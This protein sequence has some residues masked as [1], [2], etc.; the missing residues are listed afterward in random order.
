MNLKD[1][2]AFV[3]HLKKRTDRRKL[4]EKE[5]KGFKKNYEVFDAIKRHNGYEGT[6]ESFKSIIRHCKEND[7]K[8]VLIF[9][10][11]VKICSSK[12]KDK[13]QECINSL[14]EDWD[15]LL[16]GVYSLLNMGNLKNKV[17]EHLLKI[18]DF[19]SLHCT[20]INH[21]A[22]DKLLKH[23]YKKKFKHLDRY[24]G[25]LSKNKEL[26]VYLAYPMVAIQHDG[27]SDNAKTVTNY[28][29]LLERFKLLK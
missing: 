27:Y 2:K 24:L 21:T 15:I 19:S 26:N 3:I 12:S 1:I 11:D 10:D 14:P 29:R 23:D 13:F 16:G 7:I 25:N 6:S 5:L 20:L 9:E 17:G 4:F 18:D 28:S 22:Y 8:Q